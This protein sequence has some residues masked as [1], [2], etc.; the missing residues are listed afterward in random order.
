MAFEWAE[1][2]DGDAASRLAALDVT[3]E[4]LLIPV[5]TGVEA[6]R[7]T[8]RNHPLAYPG[9]VDYA[10]RVAALRDGLA[11][12]GWQA[13]ERRGLSLVEHPAGRLAIMTAVGTA[14]TGTDSAVTTVRRRGE[15]TKEVVAAN[16][17]ALDLGLDEVPPS[18]TGM[19]TYV[20]LVHR[21][22]DEVRSELSL[23][24]HIDDDGYI[25]R[26]NDRIPLPV[27]RLNETLGGDGGGDDEPPFGPDFDVPEL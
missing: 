21:D 13:I 26:W 23:A 16:Q 15:A 3:I 24:A 19:P 14:G 27:I 20:L 17:L 6:R 10:E 8:T 5:R 22:G 4:D 9:W 12:R 1:P 11:T 25:D 18:A 2:G 7:T